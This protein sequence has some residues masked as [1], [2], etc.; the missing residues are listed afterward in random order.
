M[1][2]GIILATLMMLCAC[3]PI[4]VTKLYYDEYINPKASIDYQ[5]Q[6][7]VPIPSEVLDAFVRMDGVV[8]RVAD[9]LGKVESFPD[10]MWLAAVGGAF[11]EVRQWGVFDRHLLSKNGALLSDEAPLQAFI[12]EVEDRP[13]A[14]GAVVL[15]EGVALAR[16]F[17]DGSGEEGV[18]VALLDPGLLNQ[19][20]WTAVVVG[21][22]VAY[23][24]LDAESMQQLQREI[25]KSKA[26]SGSH[27]LGETQYRWLMSARDYM[28][29]AYIYQHK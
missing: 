23:G 12:M 1:R 16:K 17:T 18:V 19:S 7:D 21:D 4:H 3:Q 9:V 10:D 8:I 22:Q 6:G 24:A 25:M 28:R 20:P 29:I 27:L 13:Y 26:F 2:R 5:A 11:P 14:L 15:P